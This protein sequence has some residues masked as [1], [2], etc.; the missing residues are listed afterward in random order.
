M[1]FFTI[2]NL[3]ELLTFG[4]ISLFFNI[5][6]LQVILNGMSLL[7]CPTYAGVPQDAI[8]G[9]SIFRPTMD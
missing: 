4:L 6:S 3:M 5:R 1:V 8:P 2:L 7:E 9:C